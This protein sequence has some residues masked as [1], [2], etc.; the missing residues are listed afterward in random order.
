MLNEKRKV[1]Q[2]M[3]LWGQRPHKMQEKK[4]E[5]LLL[6]GGKKQTDASKDGMR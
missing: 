6:P 1:N 3:Y 2:G 5:Y 4:V